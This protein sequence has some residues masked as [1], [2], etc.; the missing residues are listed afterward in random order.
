MQG[1]FPRH[2]PL[3][4]TVLFNE[5]AVISFLFEFSVFVSAF[6]FVFVFGTFVLLSLL[7]YSFPRPFSV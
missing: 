4:V 3:G 1:S 7:D 2:D 5:A 6:A